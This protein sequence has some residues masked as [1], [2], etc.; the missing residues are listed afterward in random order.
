[1]DS[2]GLDYPVVFDPFPDKNSNENK[3]NEGGKNVKTCVQRSRHDI[4]EKILTRR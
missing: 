2:S 3:S 4:A 1:M